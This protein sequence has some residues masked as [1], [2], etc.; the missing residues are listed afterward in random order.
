MGQN[1]H[2]FL[3][4]YYSSPPPQ[5]FGRLAELLQGSLVDNL[6]EKSEHFGTSAI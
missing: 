5:E 6:K 3:S 4:A 2:V 1:R